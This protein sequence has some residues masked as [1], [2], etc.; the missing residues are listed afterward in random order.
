[1]F[2]AAWM[3]FV[4]LVTQGSE[5]D[6]LKPQR[7]ASPSGEKVLWMEPASADS[8]SSCRVTA[9]QRDKVLWSAD[10]DDPM[11]HATITDAG[12]S[13]GCF[14]EG[15]PR[16]VAQGSAAKEPLLRV[17][18][19]SE[20]GEHMFAKDF[21]RS[22]R[23]TTA[24]PNPGPFPVV[25]SLSH[26]AAARTFVLQMTESIEDWLSGTSSFSFVHDKTWALTEGF[27]LEPPVGTGPS[28]ASWVQTRS[29]QHAPLLLIQWQVSDEAT[30]ESPSGRSPHSHVR[31]VDFEGEVVWKHIFVSTT[32]R[33]NDLREAEGQS[34]G[35]LT[36]LPRGFEYSEP[37][38]GPT[39]RFIV[40]RDSA[41]GQ[42]VVE[43]TSADGAPEDPAPKQP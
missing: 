38:N 20:S 12:K 30:E 14:Y 8:W 13:L 10:F 39:H 19:W 5:P 31:L 4:V 23:T 37:I 17:I 18:G 40:S 29:L 26:S 21:T 25:K 7:Y 33:S 1:M 34:T 2:S 22:H 42:W 41:T 43:P 16:G 6:V 35:S 36:V 11:T 9:L 15:G 32:Q 28:R 27:R 3:T 24:N